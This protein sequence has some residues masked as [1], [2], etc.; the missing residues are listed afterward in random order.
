MGK[1][2]DGDTV[3]IRVSNDGKSLNIHDN[4][5]PDASVS[6]QTEGDES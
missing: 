6:V 3:S 1:F 4:H 2:R 5:A